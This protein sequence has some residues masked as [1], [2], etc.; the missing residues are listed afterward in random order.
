MSQTPAATYFVNTNG[1]N[2]SYNGSMPL[3][4]GGTNGPWQTLA[5]LATATLAPNDTV[6]LAC[7]A[8]WNETL[9]IKSSGA[10]SV[11]ITIAAGPGACTTPPTIDGAV[12]IPSHQWVKHS[13]SIYKAKLPVDLITNPNPG[14]SLNGW[15]KYA[16][17]GD[18]TLALDSACP[19]QAAPCLA[20]TSG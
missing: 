18:S 1:G 11:P 14:T 16:A 7:G 2:D 10:V 6:Y 5:K 9:K 19:E 8:M 3:P 17:T 20:F 13:G 15:N 4:S 12:T